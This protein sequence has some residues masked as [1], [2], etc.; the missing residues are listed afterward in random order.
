[1]KNVKGKLKLM[2]LKVEKR[3][4]ELLLIAGVGGSIASAVWACKQTTKL[5]GI[6]EESKEQ[7]EQI[8]YYSEHQEE[9]PEGKEYTEEDAKKDLAIVYGKTAGS[10]IK[11]YAGPVILG[12]LS[13]ASIITSNNKLRKRYIASASAYAAE[14]KLFKE[15]RGRVVERFGEKMDHELRYN[16]KVEENEKVVVDE[17]GNETVVKETVEVMNSESI[18]P[19][20]RFYD[21]GCVGWEKDPEANLLFLRCQEQWASE[22]L[23]ADGYLFLNDVYESLGIP[24]CKIGQIVGWVYDEK[25]P[26]GDNYVSFGIYDG[27]SMSKRDFV[28]GYERTILLDF[29]VDGNILDLI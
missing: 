3:S 2:G 17:E 27:N 25:N 15:Y 11:L 19:Y 7:I 12:T 21:D 18:S 1:M 5:G 8:K 29:N 13:L 9:L 22:K 16:I 4:P 14:H 24:R 20:A 23:R 26:V 6:L 28:N 10:I